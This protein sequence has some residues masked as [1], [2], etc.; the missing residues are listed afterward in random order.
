M[1]KGSHGRQSGEAAERLEIKPQDVFLAGLGVLE[2][3]GR[4][5]F[6]ILKAVGA[7]A[8]ATARTLSQEIA[9][10]Q[11]GTRVE[12]L[13]P[14]YEQGLRALYAGQPD[15]A[16]ALFAEVVERSGQPE[17]VERAR[18]LRT[19]CQR[20]TRR[21]SPTTDDYLEAVLEKNR[22]NYQRALEIAKSN[23]ESGQDARF[24]YLEA[25]IHALEE[26][27]DEAAE[28]LSRA[29]ELSE[30][31]PLAVGTWTRLG[32][33][34][35]DDVGA[36][37]TALH[38]PAD[39]IR[40]PPVGYAAAPEEAGSRYGMPELIEAM[41]PRGV[42]T[43]AMVLQARRNSEARAALIE[44]FGLLTSAEIA[45]LN[46]SQAENRAALASRWKGEGR[47]FSVR[48]HGQ[49]YFPA[50][51]FAA[52]GYPLE[53]IGRILEALGGPRG[54][55]TALWFT[56][57]SGYLGGHRP[58]DLLDNEPESVVAAA[59]REGAEIYF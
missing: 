55:E 29:V 25:S 8:P 56:A 46:E 53:A 20:E 37:P 34:R 10:T 16:E 47:V 11:K 28:A 44:E 42:P 15:R 9:L 39:E 17:L 58:V 30:G 12:A 45:D 38:E 33:E 23:A 2:H 52:D 51:Q 35:A 31:E 57:A 50:F 21:A 27:L 13:L 4:E 22:G 5:R 32:E 3:E 49:D 48:H 41:T 1:S 19:V 18:Q 43:P 54:W 14:T 36:S 6:E 24:A 40:E 59:E 7:A 26:R